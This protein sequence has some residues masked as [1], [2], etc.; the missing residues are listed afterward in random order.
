[1]ADKPRKRKPNASCS[2]DTYHAVDISDPATAAAASAA[3]RRRSACNSN[4][5][6]GSSGG[7]KA[8]S[9]MTKVTSAMSQRIF[10]GKK[11]GASRSTQVMPLAAPAAA[12]SASASVSGSTTSAAA[13]SVGGVQDREHRGQDT[14]AQKLRQVSSENSLA[15]ARAESAV[16]SQ[17]PTPVEKVDF[18]P[19]VVCDIAADDSDDDGDYRRSG[20]AS[21][22]E[23]KPSSVLQSIQVGSRRGATSVSEKVAPRDQENGDED[24][25]FDTSYRRHGHHAAAFGSA[26]RYSNSRRNDED[27]GVRDTAPIL[28]D[29]FSRNASA[30]QGLRVQQRESRREALYKASFQRQERLRQRV[31][32]ESRELETQQRRMRA[33]QLQRATQQRRSHLRREAAT[34]RKQLASRLESDTRSFVHERE[35]WEGEFED[36]MCVLSR[37]FRKAGAKTTRSDPSGVEEGGTGARPM[38]VAGLAVPVALAQIRRDASNYEKRLNT[39]PPRV[40]HRDRDVNVFRADRERGEEAAAD[41]DDY[42]AILCSDGS[43]SDEEEATAVALGF[44]PPGDTASLADDARA[45][46]I[47]ALLDERQGLLR[48]IAELEKL[49]VMSCPASAA[50]RIL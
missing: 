19:S 38:T 35:R 13:A 6:N 25:D 3:W 30:G 10:S 15:R 24:C 18:C 8:E 5:S 7:S 36:E 28:K 33:E 39:A 22:L 31:E 11:L 41:E 29:F 20:R 9:W 42:E 26:T 27:A 44:L 12:A 50:E 17:V 21:V 2:D 23:A 4:S 48:R 14:K 1:M 37:A 49:V 45:F 32:A 47:E 40:P 34:A 16:A 43:N 46:T